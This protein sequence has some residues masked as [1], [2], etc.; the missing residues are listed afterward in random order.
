MQVRALIYFDEVVRA[1]SL[2]AAAER[3][4]VAPT[5]LSRQIDQLEHYFGTPLLERSARGIRLTAAGELLAERAG[6]TLREL[7]NVRQLIDDLEGLKRGR[8]VI[9]ASGAVVA[10]LLAPALADFSSRFPGIRFEIAATSARQSV[11]ALVSAEADIAVTLFSEPHPGT[12][13]RLKAEIVYELVAASDHPLAA[14]AEVSVAELARHPLALPDRG[15]GAR[16]AFDALFAA[17]GLPLDPVFVTGSLEMLKELVL[18]GV[19]VTLLPAFTVQRECR[20]GQLVARP[21]VEGR[22][23]KTPLT[24]SVATERQLPFAATKL[25][26]HIDRF[27]RESFTRAG[28]SG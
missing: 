9:H 14:L 28:S 26:D 23:L 19:A 18:S 10:S 24:L 4:N 22:A 27:L 21:L 1:R 25:L 5:A 12:K 20:L 3:L 17:A 13:V 6:R 11:E 2:R 15:F 7:D 8:V 16:Q